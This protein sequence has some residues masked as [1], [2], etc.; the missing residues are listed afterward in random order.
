MKDL[1]ELKKLH[2]KQIAIAKQACGDSE[3]YSCRL[4][5]VLHHLKDASSNILNHIENGDTDNQ[6]HNSQLWHRLYN[7]EHQVSQ[8]TRYTESSTEEFHKASDELI[9]LLKEIRPPK[10]KI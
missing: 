2:E 7:I 10:D 5:I 6:K 4:K 8:F 3:K 9:Q 1:D